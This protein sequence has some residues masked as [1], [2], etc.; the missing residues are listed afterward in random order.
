MASNTQTTN[1]D[2]L[3][4]EESAAQDYFTDAILN[5]VEKEEVQ[6]DGENAPKIKYYWSDIKKG[7]AESQLSTKEFTK[8]LKRL[9]YAF[10]HLSGFTDA[11]IDFMISFYEYL[12]GVKEKCP[13]LSLTEQQ[14]EAVQAA[15][16]ET[17]ENADAKQYTDAD[18][19]VLSKSEIQNYLEL[20]DD[21]AVLDR[22]QVSTSSDIQNA[23]LR[24]EKFF[25]SSERI[26]KEFE[27]KFNFII[28]ENNPGDAGTGEYKRISIETQKKVKESAA[29]VLPSAQ[30]KIE[31][32]APTSFYDAS[33]SELLE[34][35]SKEIMIQIND[36]ST[37][38]EE[39]NTTSEEENSSLTTNS[40]ESS[41][42]ETTT[43]TSPT[44]KAPWSAS[45]AA[46]RVIDKKLSQT[47]EVYDTDLEKFITVNEYG[48]A[49]EEKKQQ[50][51]QYLQV[52]KAISALKTERANAGIDAGANI[53]NKALNTAFQATAAW[54]ICSEQYSWEG[55]QKIGEEF[56]EA[57][58]D[59]FQR[60]YK[61][62]LTSLQAE[63]IALPADA[64]S[65]VLTQTTYWTSYYTTEIMKEINLSTLMT[66]D[67]LK[68]DFATQTANAKK[69]LENLAKTQE[70]FMKV[71][72]KI[73]YW[74]NTIQ[75]WICNGISYVVE[76]PDIALRY[77]DNFMDMG[78]SYTDYYYDWALKEGKEFLYKELA[79]GCEAAGKWAS[80]KIVAPIKVDLQDT[81]T[82]ILAMK[83]KA[84]VVA[85]EKIAVAI[86]KIAALVGL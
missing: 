65:Y 47:Y 61:N 80:E 64:T 75:T 56:K 54:Q 74:T 4:Q 72:N 79:I 10:S 19:K 60:Y 30:D 71:I 1:N 13:M 16:T 76:A 12:D 5:D 55:I 6:G 8:V 40:S 52:K 81:K 86:S 68:I 66:T 44:T 63:L 9:W 50:K 41:S 83:A 14:N 45:A 7:F 58:W 35:H 2:G 38:E 42:S 29:A 48:L 73:T 17:I 82:Q 49:T 84:L 51:E 36:N 24:W 43:T 34:K 37:S 22:R 33:F 18:G 21:F 67:E 69:K 23:V 53:L 32:G 3:T 46:Q 27:E 70:K 78:F 85:S 59:E 62:K 31:G 77:V 20:N 28:S 25:N 26:L 39:T 15:R 11:K 57:T